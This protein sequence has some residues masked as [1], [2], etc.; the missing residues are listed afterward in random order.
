MKVGICVLMLLG[1]IALA[2][3]ADVET[4]K[5]LGN[6]LAGEARTA[7]LASPLSPMSTD[8][9]ARFSRDDGARSRE[10]E[11]SVGPDW[12]ILVAEDASLLTKSMAGHLR[13]FLG[14]SMKLELSVK[15]RPAREL[16][17]GQNKAI[18]LTEQGGGKDGVEESFTITI[19]PR[20]V[21]LAG[22]DDRGLRDA[23][24][25]LVDQ[26]GMRRA[27]ILAQGS[28][29]YTPKLAIRIGAV[30]YFGQ[31]RDLVFLGNNAIVAGASLY[32]VSTSDAI[33]DLLKRRKSD[34]LEALRKQVQ[35][36]SAYGLHSYVILDTRQKFPANDPVFR[37]HPDIRG[38]LTWK[39]DGE[40][41]LCTQHPLVR[42]YLSESVAG[43]M[44][45]CPGVDGAIIIVG[46]EGFYHCYMRPLGGDKGHTN[47][48]R[49]EK[50]GP[51][52]VVADLCNFL[53]EAARKVNPRAQVIAWPYSA[54]HVWSAEADQA[55]FI[56]H[57]KAGTAIMTEVEKDE[58]VDKPM[59]VRKHLWDYSIDM[60]GLGSRC[61]SQI[62]ACKKVGIPI[63]LKS[64]P[65]CTFE[66]P[67]LSHV[68]ALDRWWARA[69]AMANSGAAGSIN[70]PCFRGAM[71]GTSV[72]EVWK[73]ANWDPAP[74]D[75]L[76]ALANRIAGN[77]EAGAHLR[78]AWKLVSDSIQFS[79][80]L[81]PYYR[82]PYYLG[83]AQPMCCNRNA[84]LPE[85]F[86]GR[87]L[88]M[89]ESTDAEGLALR[90]T[91][92]VDPSGD[93]AVFGKMYRQM[94]DCL[95]QAEQEVDKAD[96]LA[97]K[98][99]RM[100][101]ESE[102]SAIRWFAHATRTQANF[103]ESCQIRD[104]LAAGKLTDKRAAL[105]RWAAVLKDER[106][107]TAAALAVMEADVR[108]DFYYGGDHTFSHGADM[109]RA[110]LKLIDEEIKTYLPSLGRP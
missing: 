83:P 50:L 20:Q 89:A 19:A 40:Y 88:F 44:R 71:Y 22:R 95:A 72:A 9:F 5:Q 2:D 38:A 81:P 67:G 99:G 91:Y 96:A 62:A 43:L 16:A 63:Y 41:V 65:E 37:N 24:V 53:A 28:Q 108:L 105:E 15:Q 39:A 17:A 35:A 8:Y 13:D 78:Q 73:Y 58:F 55:G 3:A 110:K 94:A 97:P 31:M 23:V 60:P 107:N 47:C 57:L 54:Q 34:K 69:T 101:F 46:G 103:Y 61:L 64:E 102:A 56:A 6:R 45:D 84:G 32:E 14:Q 82:G 33:P 27:P 26:M 93:V 74:Q 68:P 59:G 98:T 106:A 10:G 75:V 49:C 30:P 11:M 25:K 90:E 104:Q 1:F 52:V 7:Y 66:A 51:D 42:Q 77:P 100:A 79:P 4:L 29:I 85:V 18:V 109:I 86:L 87:F 70:F 21:T 92:M 12:T 36:A 48:A 80:E 76:T